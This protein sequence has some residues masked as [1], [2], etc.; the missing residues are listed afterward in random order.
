M[1]QNQLKVLANPS[2]CLPDVCAFLYSKNVWTD[3]NKMLYI[4]PST[5]RLHWFQTFENVIFNAKE[6]DDAGKLKLLIN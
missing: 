1:G 5:E 3:F 4:F 6:I 2:V